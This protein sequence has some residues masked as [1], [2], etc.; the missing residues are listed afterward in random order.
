M[1]RTEY[2]QAWIQP[3]VNGT[4]I[5]PSPIHRT[6]QYLRSPLNTPTA[7]RSKNRT[8]IN[9]QTVGSVSCAT[10]GALISTLTKT[11]IE[12]SLRP[13]NCQS[14]PSTARGF[15][16][17]HRVLKIVASDMDNCRRTN[18][19]GYADQQSSIKSNAQSGDEY[20]LNWPCVQPGRL[21]TAT[22]GEPPYQL[23]T[24]KWMNGQRLNIH[25]PVFEHTKRRTLCC[26]NVGLYDARIDS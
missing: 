1:N 21:S 20:L 14:S 5:S 2:F 8:R 18:E 19:F 17:L 4:I 13:P 11:K 23:F 24:A 26:G 10:L 22:I 6:E 12:V 15:Q 25:C 9:S 3:L 16:S 7:D